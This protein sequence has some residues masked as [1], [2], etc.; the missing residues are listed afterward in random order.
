MERAI[1]NQPVHNRTLLGLPTITVNAR[2]RFK[3]LISSGA[4]ISLMHMNV[5]NMIEDHYKTSILP[6]AIH[7]KIVDGS[8]MSPMGKVTSFFELLILNFHTPSLYVENYQKLI[9]YLALISRKD[10]HYLIAWTWTDNY[11]YREK[12]HSDLH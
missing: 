3:A 12:A 4:A 1:I 5:Y 8:T 2:K 6:I 7:L 10:T 11:S 9:F